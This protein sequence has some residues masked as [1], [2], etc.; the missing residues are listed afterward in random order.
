M[1]DKINEEVYNAING[2]KLDIIAPSIEGNIIEDLPVRRESK[3][4]AYINIQLGCDKFCTYCIVPYTRGKQ[5]SRHKEDILN[6][7]IKLKEEGYKEITLLGQNVN[8]YGKDLY[9]N[10]TM[11][12][13]LED[14]AYK[15]CSFTSS[16]R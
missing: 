16:I 6:E 1:L 13:L 14:V 3:Y 4:K 5:R 15:S 10:Y 8:A 11:A 9:D 12:N 2:S 7:V